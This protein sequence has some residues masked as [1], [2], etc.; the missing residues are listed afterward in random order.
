MDNQSNPFFRLALPELWDDMCDAVGQRMVAVTCR[1][2]AQR[3]PPPRK[4]MVHYLVRAAQDGNRAILTKSIICDP[5]PA[6]F[7]P[8]ADAF[9]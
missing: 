1:L 3:R 6:R 7:A 2:G 9:L 8:I 5:D 4:K